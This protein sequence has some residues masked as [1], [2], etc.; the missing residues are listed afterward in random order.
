MNLSKYQCLVCDQNRLRAFTTFWQCEGC[1]E[2]YATVK[3][4]PRLY[5]EQDLGQ[6]DRALRDFFYNGFLG[7]YYRYVM[8]F[9]ALPVRPAYWNGWLAYGLIVSLLLALVG[10]LANFLF[11]ANRWRTPSLLDVSALLMFLGLCY[12]LLRHRY[13]LYLL[14]LA[15]PFNASLRS[16]RPKTTEP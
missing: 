8:P 6:H 11:F 9:L 14:L 2:R 10:H 15:L 3:G 1:G 7:K 4:I 12:F 13:L 5:L 16:S